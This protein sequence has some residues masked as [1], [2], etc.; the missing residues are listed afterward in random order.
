M[1]SYL[2]AGPVSEPIAL[3]EARA[4]LR[5]DDTAEDA[6]VTTLITAARLHVEGVTGRALINQ[7]WRLVLDAW[8]NNGAVRLPV[9]PFRSLVAVRAYDEAGTA[10]TVGL[11]QFLP[12]AGSL[13][14]RLL[15]PPVVAGMP[16]LRRNLGLEIDFVA[17]FG[18]SG[19][20]V[21]AD[22][23]QAL[24]VLVAHWFEHRDAVVIAGS[25]ALVPAGID[26][27]MEP[28]RQVRL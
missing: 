27:L 22:L 3:A 14:A 13:P 5:L 1:T 7:T 4:F 23:R 20:D 18:P 9:A 8:P 17:G 28:Y 16:V 24:L 12:E 15:L 25:G 2:L 26:R 21:P 6:F 19:S 11:T 10:H